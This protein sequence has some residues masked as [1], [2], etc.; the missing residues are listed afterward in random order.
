MVLMV[1]IVHGVDGD[2]CML[3]KKNLGKIALVS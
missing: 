2:N 3:K 1:I